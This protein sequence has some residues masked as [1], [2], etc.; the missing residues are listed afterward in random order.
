R[1]TKELCRVHN[2]FHT[3][4]NELQSNVASTQWYEDHRQVPS[5][6]NQRNGR[7]QVMDV[8]Y[9]N[10]HRAFK[11]EMGECTNGGRPENTKIV[12]EWRKTHPDGR[13]ADCQRDTGLDP[14]TIRKRRK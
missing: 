14:K 13:T 8:K 12:E 5:R 9:M 2:E 7:K 6:R 3:A 10:N 1:C 4:D 11:V